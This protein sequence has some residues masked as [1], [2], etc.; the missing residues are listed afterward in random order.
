MTCAV[1]SFAI[2]F[3]AAFALCLIA[4]PIERVTK[5]CRVR[6]TPHDGGYTI[7]LSTGQQVGHF[8][9]VGDAVRCASRNGMEVVSCR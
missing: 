7:Q 6:V 1:I 4:L 5:P 9:T 2:G 8:A 3:L